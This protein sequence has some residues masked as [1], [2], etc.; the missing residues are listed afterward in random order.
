MTSQTSLPDLRQQLPALEAA[1]EQALA[2]ARA[3]GAD[4]AQAQIGLR[5]GYWVGVRGGDVETLEHERDRGLGVTVYFGGR[6][7][8][9]STT[10]LRVEAIEAA[11]N[12]ACDLAALLPAS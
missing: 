8:G 12:A 4:A 9:A 3:R 11:V 7:G 1:V 6:K 10:D 5:V 2:R